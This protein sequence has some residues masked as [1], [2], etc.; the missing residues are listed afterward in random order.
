MEG[1]LVNGGDTTLSSCMLSELNVES[2]GSLSS[3]RQPIA[4]LEKMVTHIKNLRPSSPLP[5][6][7]TDVRALSRLFDVLQQSSVANGNSHAAHAEG[8]L[9]SAELE[10]LLH[11]AVL[12]N[13]VDTRFLVLTPHLYQSISRLLAHYSSAVQLTDLPFQACILAMMPAIIHSSHLVLGKQ[14]ASEFLQ[15]QSLQQYHLFAL[16]QFGSSPIVL[17]HVHWLPYFLLVLRDNE[18]PAG[19]QSS[20]SAAAAAH[21]DPIIHSD[22]GTV[23]LLCQRVD[24]GLAPPGSSRVSRLFL[25]NMARLLVNWLGAF[26]SQLD[27]VVA[28]L[29]TLRRVIVRGGCPPVDVLEQLVEPLHALLVLDKQNTDIISCVLRLFLAID[30]EQVPEMG[31]SVSADLLQ[32]LGAIEQLHADDTQL[33]YDSLRVLL[34]LCSLP[35]CA[36]ML[37][38]NVPLMTT[39]LRRI[40]MHSSAVEMMTDSA[41]M[42]RLLCV[43]CSGDV[44]SESLCMETASAV[45]LNNSSVDSVLQPLA[46]AMAMLTMDRPSFVLINRMA[47]MTFDTIRQ[48]LFTADAS[49]GNSS[50]SGMP[51]EPRD[52]AE[53]VP[54]LLQYRMVEVLISGYLESTKPKSLAID[55]LQVLYSV[56]LHPS[57]DKEQLVRS[58]LKTLV[59]SLFRT[60]SSTG[61]DSSSLAQHQ[62]YAISSMLANLLCDSSLLSVAYQCGWMKALMDVADFD[63]D[64]TVLSCSPSAVEICVDNV[65]RMASVKDA[66]QKR[67]MLND[68]VHLFFIRHL[69]RRPEHAS[70]VHR[71]CSALCVLMSSTA[72]KSMLIDAGIAHGL[73]NVMRHHLADQNITRVMLLCVAGL[74]LT[75]R[76]HRQVLIATR[77]HEAAHFALQCGRFSSLLHTLAIVVMLRLVMD[78]G[79]INDVVH[80]ESLQDSVLKA[81]Q[82]RSPK[83]ADSCGTDLFQCGQSLLSNIF[84]SSVWQRVRMLDSFRERGHTSLQS[85]VYQ[86]AVLKYTG[87][88]PGT[89]LMAYPRPQHPLVST[90]MSGMALHMCPNCRNGLASEAILT[91]PSLSAPEYEKLTERGWF[92]RGGVQLFQYRSNHA[93]EC[94]TSEIRVRVKEFDPNS[95]R[96]FARVRRKA[97]QAGVRVKVVKPEYQQESYALYLRYQVERHESE[98]CCEQTYSSHLLQSPLAHEMSADGLYEYG[99]FHYQYWVGEHLAGVSVVDVLPHSIGSIYMF[100]DI[101]KQYSRLSLGVF[102]CLTEL[103]FAQQLNKK[104]ADIRYYYLGNYCPTNR[105]LAYKTDYQPTEVLCP[106]ISMEWSS[107]TKDSG[108]YLF[109]DDLPHNP[110]HEVMLREA[111]EEGRAK[112]QWQSTATADDADAGTGEA[113][114]RIYSLPANKERIVKNLSSPYLRLVAGYPDRER[115]NSAINRLRVSVDKKE[116]SFVDMLQAYCV[117]P[118]CVGRLCWTMDELYRAFGADTF[119]RLIIHFQYVSSTLWVEPCSQSFI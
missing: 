64:S 51:A 72:V 68:G 110:L 32:E 39:T 117:H 100:F 28:V 1:I 80:L 90:R 105:K 9:I 50:S 70:V 43:L 97:A 60:L 92:R 59:C 27:V 34:R 46:S 101:D 61:Q 65:V 42:L 10:E 47:N 8:V 33:C 94:N 57:V 91:F 88:G 16:Q 99:T 75:D 31:R 76:T 74:S 55:V 89:S 23:L 109:S 21:G 67:D 29:Q 52:P 69:R 44:T 11:L 71:I 26:R 114:R 113:R 108:S 40:P 19:N 53:N 96:S 82:D 5:R 85:K 104:G 45:L 48:E 98:F 30:V 13:D 3:R 81:V 103:E 12:L 78:E 63:G 93:P 6:K 77:L 119:E 25:D 107:H 87:L 7:L 54:L 38:R 116:M 37:A 20:T 102:S 58:S 49:S 79:D 24:D 4:D 17:E 35:Q 95:S 15:A 22:F 14:G 2:D 84:C 41:R 106:H 111:I 18:L 73:A 62:Q 36:V 56:A 115:C 118:Y 66:Q 112:W 83:R 86:E